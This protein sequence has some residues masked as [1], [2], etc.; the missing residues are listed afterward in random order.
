MSLFIFIS[1]LIFGFLVVL[2]FTQKINLF[3]HL[4]LSFLFGLGLISYLIFIFS[5]F[6][7]EINL[8]KILLLIVFVNLILFFVIFRA[9]K[10]KI[11]KVQNFCI[12]TFNKRSFLGCIFILLTVFFVFT[13]TVNNLYW[14]VSDW[15][16][17]ALY[18]FRARVF[19]ETGEILKMFPTSWYYSFP[20]F[21]S[22]SHAIFYF[23]ETANPMFIYTFLYVSFIVC[24]YFLLRRNI[25]D[26]LS[27]FFS[28]VLSFSFPLF[29]HAQ[30]SY[31]N[32]PYTV[33]LSL[34]FLYL[35]DWISNNTEGSLS[36]SIIFV[37]LSTWTRYLE[38]LWFVIL[39][40]VFVHSIKQSKAQIFLAYLIALLIYRFPWSFFQSKFGSYFPSTG[41]L[42]QNYT[43][44]LLDN[45]SLMKMIGIMKY[46]WNY[47][48]K[49]EISLLVSYLILLVINYKKY[50]EKNLYSLMF[51]LGSV[52]VVFLG[53]YIFSIKESAKDFTQMGDSLSRL[54]M[55]LI[56]ILLFFIAKNT[57]L[58][59]IN[60]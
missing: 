1:I 12:R 38:P 34:G 29:S 9:K 49:E 18:D 56:P 17:L 43:L 47:F 37:C 28:C 54:S 8:F 53:S 14:P 6:D 24:F 27:L 51:V 11:N 42:I 23:G 32:L 13:V 44:L 31:T 46:V 60:E 2:L 50:W 16:A 5:F 4:S 25:S 7:W 15:D 35:Y 20:L 3:E 40:I 52:I 33:F 22:I 48:I 30:I 36:I 59:L 21:N 10:L 55:F 26:Q 45:L 19:V 39:I 58:L 57:H 41:S